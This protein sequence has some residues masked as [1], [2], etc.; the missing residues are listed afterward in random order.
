MFATARVRTKSTAIA[1][2]QPAGCP[3]A[4]CDLPPWSL[5][6][7]RFTG[8]QGLLPAAAVQHAWVLV[9]QAS[10]GGGGR[11]GAVRLVASARAVR[12]TAGSAREGHRLVRLGSKGRAQAMLLRY[13][14]GYLQQWVRHERGCG[15]SIGEPPFGAVARHSKQEG[16]YL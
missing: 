8:R 15:Y 10:Q 3:A 9:L 13:G 16:W 14:E 2:A 12:M 11:W 5:W 6:R 1:A 4:A 7:V